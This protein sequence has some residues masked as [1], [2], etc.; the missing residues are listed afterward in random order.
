MYGYEGHGYTHANAKGAS[1]IA[2]QRGA[3]GSAG[4]HCTLCSWATTRSSPLPLRPASCSPFG[5]T[6]VAAGAL[7]WPPY[8]PAMSNSHGERH[9]SSYSNHPLLA[10][11]RDAPATLPAG[12]ELAATAT[13]GATLLSPGATAAATTPRAAAAPGAVATAPTPVSLCLAPSTRRH[14]AGPRKPAGCSFPGRPCHLCRSRVTN[15]G[16]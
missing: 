10:A 8:A 14:V 7:R 16:P 1:L 5:A 2:C 3:A 15:A 9:P 11:R 12:W 4:E 6:C 13:S